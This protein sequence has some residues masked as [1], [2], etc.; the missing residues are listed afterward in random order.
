M[1]KKRIAQTIVDIC[2]N[3]AAFCMD[4]AGG[5]TD[6]FLSEIYEK[7]DE[8]AFLFSVDRYLATFGVRGH[9]YFYKKGHVPY[10]GFR[11]RQYKDSLF[12]TYSEEELPLEKGDEIVAI[13]GKSIPQVVEEN[14]IFFG[15][16]AERCSD[17]WEKIISYSDTVTVKRGENTFEYTICTDIRS[18][19]KPPYERKKLTDGCFYIRLDNF[20]DDAK[21]KQ[22]LEECKEEIENTPDLMIDVRENSGGNDTVFL[23]LLKY[24]LKENDAM[25]GKPIFTSAEEMLCTERNA[26]NRIKLLRSY[27]EKATSEAECQYFETRIL[28]QLQNKGRGFIPMAEDSFLFAERGTRLPEK[29]ILLTDCGCGSSGESFVEIAAGLEKVTVI[30]RPTMGICDYSNLAYV[31]FGEY[32]LHYPTSRSKAIDKG[33]GTR[34]RGFQPKIL[35]PWTPKH[36]QEDMDIVTALTLLR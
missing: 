8:K 21:M 16:P 31:D 1:T 30:G 2:K 32:V 29:V 25:C 9:L 13:D 36:I 11:L 15:E 3:D 35:I 17:S 4:I 27:L 12:V 28:E 7:T 26:E 34:G 19:E 22:F 24:C 33:E 6:C 20:F 14:L 10:I 5:D 23:P 18:T